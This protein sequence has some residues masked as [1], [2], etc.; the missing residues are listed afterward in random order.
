MKKGMRIGLCLVLGLCTTVTAAF[1]GGRN[2]AGSQASADGLTT[3][4][5]W[6]RNYRFV[7]GEV[8]VT[9][10][11][12]Y[13]GKSPSRRWS[14]FVQ[15]LA[16]MGIKLD[17][18]LVLDDQYQTAFQT[19]R[20]TG[21]FNNYD[22]LLGASL[23]LPTLSSLVDQN[24]I[25]ALNQAID[26]YS[27][28]RAKE[29]FTS[30]NGAEVKS[31]F[32]MPDGNYYWMPAIYQ[33]NYKG[34]PVGT[35]QMGHIRK[36]WL[37]KVGLPMPQSADELY[38]ALYQFQEQDVNKNGIKDEVVVVDI[39]SF[40]D[41][42]A[43]LFGIPIDQGGE[44]LHYL[45]YINGTL[46]S[47]WYQ[48]G[49]RDY[50]AFMNRLYRAGLIRTVGQ[51]TDEVE[52]KYA[53]KNVFLGSTNEAVARVPAGEKGA[54][55]LPLLFSAVP[56]IKPTIWNAGTLTPDPASVWIVP[57]ASQKV[58]TAVKMI[59]WY[60]TE[61]F[62][63]LMEP[64]IEGYTFNYD[65]NGVPINFIDSNQLGVD[66]LR[67]YSLWAHAIAPWMQI[68]NWYSEVALAVNNGKDL[69]YPQGFTEKET[70]IDSLVMNGTYPFSWAT[71]SYLALSTAQE[72]DRLT[73]ILPDLKTYV[74]ELHS[75]LVTGEKGL[76]DASWNG[77]LADL[78][79]M[80]LD[81][82]ISIWQARINRGG[83]K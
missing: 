53:Y 21:Q 73:A 27:D 63:R 64:G 29:F 81:E 71:T 7:Q 65:A 1:A 5:M 26:R 35:I 79:R 18:T 6:G 46:Q 33:L 34:Y 37:D 11:D 82:V 31:L 38:N 72:Q 67:R 74:E 25:V 19:L 77:Y 10:Q 57:T 17:L 44:G 22:M 68:R 55:Y 30:G 36:D 51:P 76:D 58:D 23:G 12:Q 3:L 28:G 43:Q 80:G 9:L 56:G 8:S 62:W 54:Y 41:G 60:V 66:G 83:R 32:T 45:G 16:D 69:G 47:A 13:E 70:I 49:V 24:R 42:I 48:S 50:F 4:R 39:A 52:N 61:D 14:T 40:N 2:Q 75:N 78:K 20:A 59:D 15:R